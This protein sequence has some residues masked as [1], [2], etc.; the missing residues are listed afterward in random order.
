MGG[1]PGS[2]SLETRLRPG[3]GWGAETGLEQG[4]LLARARGRP[5]VPLSEPREAWALGEGGQE[6][7]MSGVGFIPHSC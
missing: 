4:A 3:G 7:V 2:L 6:E 5:P 1:A